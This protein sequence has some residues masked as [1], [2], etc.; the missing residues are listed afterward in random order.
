MQVSWCPRMRLSQLRQLTWMCLDPLILWFS[1]VIAISEFLF[2]ASVW[3]FLY[4]GYFLFSF[5]NFVPC[6]CLFVHFLA[7][8]SKSA[9]NRRIFVVHFP[10]MLRARYL[11]YSIFTK[12]SIAE[13]CI[14]SRIII[15]KIITGVL[16]PGYHV[17]RQSSQRY[18]IDV[19][20]PAPKEVDWQDL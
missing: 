13:E 6:S 17:I 14:I 19:K 7:R 9:L 5:K 10:C 12:V 16:A 18:I 3:I 20:Y 1:G 2:D 11:F 15:N 8:S 4:L